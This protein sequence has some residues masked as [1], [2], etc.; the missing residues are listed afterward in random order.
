MN[1]TH[2]TTQRGRREREREER[3]RERE[4][5]CPLFLLFHAAAICN[6][7]EYFVE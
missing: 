6:I 7:Q 2:L 5:G 3:E 1:A 4:K